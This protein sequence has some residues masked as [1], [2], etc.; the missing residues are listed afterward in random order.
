MT[1]I[2][3]EIE[4]YLVRSA[5]SEAERRALKEAVLAQSHAWPW[6][7]TA[8]A[9]ALLA[10]PALV[11]LAL[12]VRPDPAPEQPVGPIALSPSERP[13]S[14]QPHVSVRPDGAGTAL[15]GRIDWEQGTIS[16]E[17]T[18]HQGVLLEVLT[19]EASVRVVG[20]A[21]AVSRDLFGTAVSVQRG[22]VSVR[23]RGS[24]PEPLAAGSSLRCF[25]S[26]ETGVGYALSLER[27]RAPAEERLAAVR[28]A[29]RAP[30]S[31]PETPAALLSLEV[32]ALLLLSRTPEAAGI[33]AE[34]LSSGQGVPDRSLSAVA[35]AAVTSGDCRAALPALS[36]LAGRGD[37]AAAAWLARCR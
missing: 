11:L 31:S 12:L 28:R 8:A 32:D 30:S 17:V 4:G 25:S 23:C 13:L 29:K 5:P 37:A 34:A 16:V 1:P 24:S 22:E 35:A 14:L 3:D 36:A 15:P 10:A 2:R 6:A 18:P 9:L 27:Q 7:R 19:E 20:T 33:V 26:A 21:F